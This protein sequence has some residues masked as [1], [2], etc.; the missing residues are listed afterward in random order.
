MFEELY[1]SVCM[2]AHA[3]VH[4]HGCMHVCAFFFF[5]LCGI[6]KFVEMWHKEDFSFMML[7]LAISRSKDNRFMSISAHARN[8][9]VHI[10]SFVL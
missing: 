4:V 3:C 5:F 6:S 8:I 7:L 2:C 1:V 10:L 9:G